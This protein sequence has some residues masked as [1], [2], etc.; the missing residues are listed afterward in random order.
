LVADTGSGEMENDMPQPGERQ[1][2]PEMLQEVLGFLAGFFAAA[3]H[4]LSTLWVREGP[5]VRGQG[6]AVTCPDVQFWYE[7]LSFVVTSGRVSFI[8]LSFAR[9]MKLYAHLM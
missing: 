3:L 4:A 5:G 1:V 9:E 8:L 7:G 6:Y 2:K